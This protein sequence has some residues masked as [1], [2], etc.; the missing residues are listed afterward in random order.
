[1]SIADD[2]IRLEQ[3][4]DRG[5]LSADEF[6]RAKAWLLAGD[7]PAEPLLRSLNNF[8]RSA[9]DRWFAGLCGGLA[10]ATGMAS[11]LWRLLFTLML[12]CGG[13]GLVLYVVLWVFVPLQTEPGQLAPR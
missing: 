13:A 7:A 4:R 1:M 2:L 12:L 11:W 9:S 6:L 10:Q 5:S 3:L 8:R